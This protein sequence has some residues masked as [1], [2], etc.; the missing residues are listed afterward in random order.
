MSMSCRFA[1]VCRL[2]SDI[3]AVDQGVLA[4]MVEKR[5]PC[6]HNPTIGSQEAYSFP[7]QPRKRPR[8]R[9]APGL[10]D[11]LASS[12][13]GSRPAPVLQCDTKAGQLPV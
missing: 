4:A 1:V 3:G 2:Q 11:P 10:T 12:L 9:D 5:P 13:S 6:G 8:R 7:T